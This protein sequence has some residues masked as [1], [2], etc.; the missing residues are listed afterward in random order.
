MF[1]HLMPVYVCLCW[2]IGLLL[3]AG[4]LSEQTPDILVTLGKQEFLRRMGAQEV[5]S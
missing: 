1:T 2:T 4:L 3:V 5:T